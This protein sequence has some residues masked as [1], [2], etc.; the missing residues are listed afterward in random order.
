MDNSAFSAMLLLIMFVFSIKVSSNPLY[1]FCSDNTGNYTSNSTFENNLKWVLDSLPSNTSGTGF[2]ST[3]IGEGV[4]RVYARALC[5]GDVNATLCRNCVKNA[6]R[7]VLSDCKT[8]EGIVWYDDCQVQYSFQ[9]SSLM[10]YTGKYPD[11]NNK[12]KNISNPGRFDDVLTFLMNNVSNDAAYDSELMFK[13]GEVKVNK[14]ETLYGLVQCTRDIVGDSCRSCLDSALKD[15][16]GCCRSR[17]GGSVLSRNCN[18]RFQIYKF[19]DVMNSPLIYPESKTGSKW[20][21]GMIIAVVCAAVLV[22]ALVAVSGF[23]YTR[24]KKLK[25]KDAERSQTILLYELA[26]PKEV[27]ITQEG[28]LVTAQEFPFLDLAT[29]RVATDDFSDSNKLGQGGFGTVYKGVLPNGKEVAIKRLSRKSWQG[30]EELKNEVIL[31][32]KLQHRNLVRLL[33]CGIEG[34]EKLLIYELMPNKSLDFF[35][36]DPEKRSQI[37]WKTWFDIITGISRGLLYLHE[38]SRLKIIHRDL[39]PSNV[40]LDQY[41]VAKISDFGM[42]RIF[43]ENQNAG[44][45]KRVV[46]TYGYMAPEYAMEGLF[47]VKSD[48]FSFGVIV[49]EILSGKKNSGFYQTKHAQTLLAYAW[50]LW[51]EGKELELIDHCLLESCS[52]PEIRRCIHVGLLCVQED[53]TD[54]PTMSDVVVVLESDKITLRPPKRPAFSVGRMITN[55]QSSI[56]DPSM[57]QMT[58]SNISAR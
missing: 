2:Y 17:T 4:D 19:Y 32:A 44:N 5:R 29:I 50:G 26:S 28:E 37:D 58:M 43:C 20:S 7:D 31:I 27:I 18:V 1:T 49:L 30:L 40:L 21:F 56:I 36:F 38:D 13:T 45:T 46:G 51:K 33:G 12:E 52:I 54:R 47:S 3:L 55:Y 35:I 42:A 14:K 39:K 10:V 6:S 9:N 53:P 34:D 11:S 48:V 57:N 16:N 15:L 24:L 8:L 22:V 25:Q 41:M 23:V